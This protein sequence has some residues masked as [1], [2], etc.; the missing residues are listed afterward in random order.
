MN[1][2][3]RRTALGLLGVMPVLGTK[4]F[5]ASAPLKIA[6]IGAGKM[7]APLGSLFAKAGH[8]VMFSSRHPENLKSL[9]DGLGPKARAGTVADAVAFGEVI[10]LLVP[11]SAMPDLAK[12]HGKALA[13]KPLVLDVSNPYPERDG[14][15]GRIGREE[16][17]GPYLAK[18]LPGVKIV[19]AFNAINYGKLAEFSARKGEVA[20]P[21]CGDDSKAV[22]LAES[23]I[24]EIGFGPVMIGTCSAKSKFTIPGQAIGG[25]HT[26]AEAKKIA[27]TLK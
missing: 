8:E 11:Y 26:V 10:I 19:R 4:A 16:G 12:E 15:P 18:L 27:E 20:A 25:E 2:A 24:K 9:V 14:E 17:A 23:L 1:R 3:S 21:L 22:A 13:T 6:T 7:G 5:A